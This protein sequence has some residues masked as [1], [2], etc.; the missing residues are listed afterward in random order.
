MGEVYR[1]TDSRLGRQIALKVLPKEFSRDD[2]LRSRFIEEA[3]AASA[4]NHPNVVGIHDV[5]QADEIFYIVSELV[6]G[7]SLRQVIIRGRLTPSRI[8]DLATQ[9]ADGLASAHAAGIVHRDLKPE[10]IL[11][12]RAGHVKIIDFGLAKQALSAAAHNADSPHTLTMPGTVMGTI[13]YMSPEQI[14]GQQADTRTDIFS[15]G[16]ILFEMASGRTAFSGATVPEV[17]SATLKD[18][19]PELQVEGLPPGLALI[20]RR[21]LEKDPKARFQSASDLAFAIRNLTAIPAETGAKPAARQQKKSLA[22]VGWVAAAVILLAAAG[23]WM[24]RLN[25][26]R[27]TASTPTKA[28][29]RQAAAAPIPAAPTTAPA[30]GIAEK[31]APSGHAAVPKPVGAVVQPAPIPPAPA[32]PPPSAAEAGESTVK[33]GQ[34]SKTFARA[35]QANQ[36]GDYDAAITLFTAAIRLKPDAPMAYL[37]RGR[38]YLRLK[39][40]DMALHDLTVAI[41]LKPDLAQAHAERGRVHNQ[42]G[43]YRPAL[44]DFNEALRLNPELGGVYQARAVAKSNLGDSAGAAA[45]RKQAKQHSR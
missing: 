35:Q 20:I 28:P 44:D 40:L 8:V 25:A 1:A 10:N 3:K 27:P 34:F 30:R 33:G 38:A 22:W 17:F 16:I 29:A 6:D 37:G 23:W 5:G 43:E 9:I 4:L 13:G 15:L 7:E 45:D 11:V 24:L 41:G 12:T 39:K 42:L 32:A 36:D 21:C 31:P 14:C 26:A 2:T 19:P 18:D